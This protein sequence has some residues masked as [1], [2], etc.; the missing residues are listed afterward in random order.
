METEDNKD[1]IDIDYEKEYEILTYQLHCAN[2][3]IEM[4]RKALLNVCLTMK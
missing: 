4:Y 1:I 3:Q 2:E